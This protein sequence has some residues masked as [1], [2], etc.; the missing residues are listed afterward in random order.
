MKNIELIKIRVK[1]TPIELFLVEVYKEF[2]FKGEY[3]NDCETIEEV[4]DKF[5]KETRIECIE[6]IEIYTFKSSK[7][8][9]DENVY[10][11]LYE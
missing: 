5:Y 9:V 7:D 10:E 1:K 2:V 8:Y 6:F 4:R 3:F 11:T